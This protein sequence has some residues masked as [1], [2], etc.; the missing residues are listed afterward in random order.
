MKKTIEMT[1]KIS[2]IFNF[3]KKDKL[4]ILCDY[5]GIDVQVCC[6]IMKAHMCSIFSVSFYILKALYMYIF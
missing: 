1:N 6:V 4:C 5:E 2:Y 3:L